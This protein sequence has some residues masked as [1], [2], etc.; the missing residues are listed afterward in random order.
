MHI[1]F[2]YHGQIIGQKGATIRQ[3]MEQYD[4]NISI[5]PSAERR[6]QVKIIG[7]A[8]KIE[9]AQK[10]LEERVQQLDEEKKQKVCL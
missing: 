4:V 7:T 2:D 8:E 5:P 10:A 1:P 6:D 3:L 9:K